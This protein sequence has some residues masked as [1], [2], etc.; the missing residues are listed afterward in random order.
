MINTAKSI[1]SMT[2]SNAIHSMTSLLSSLVNRVTEATAQQERDNRPLYRNSYFINPV[3]VVKSN[4]MTSKR[5]IPRIWDMASDSYLVEFMLFNRESVEEPDFL[6][7]ANATNSTRFSKTRQTK[8]IIHDYN[9]TYSDNLLLR[10]KDAYLHHGDL[11]VILVDWV[12]ARRYSYTVA[13][14][15]TEYVGVMCARLVRELDAD[16]SLLH[17]V[18]FGLGAHAAGI[19]GSELNG[20]ISRITGLD[21]SLPLFRMVT[22]NQKLDSEDASFVDVFHSDGGDTFWHANHL[23]MGNIMGHVDVYVNQGIFQPGCPAPNLPSYEDMYCSHI[24]SL[25]LFVESV[26]NKESTIGCSCDSWIAFRGMKCDCTDKMIY[27]G[28]SCPKKAKGK[29]YMV[30]RS[31]YPYGLGRRGAF[32]AGPK[33]SKTM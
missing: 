19:M 21:P 15:V 4:S 23:G 2:S 3:A 27:V 13:A 12:Q 30:T 29:F 22:D 10:L 18:G 9:Q 24:R 11:N 26:E 25:Q 16:L 32:P 31:T 20:K 7:V 17:V 1:Q 8:L 33:L 28:N 5:Q 6:L 14:R